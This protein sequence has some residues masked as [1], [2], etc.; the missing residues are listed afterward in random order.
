MRTAES[1]RTLNHPK[2]SL[3][4]IGHT[5][6]ALCPFSLGVRQAR[7]RHNVLCMAGER[8]TM[9]REKEKK[10]MGESASKEQGHMESQGYFGK[11]RGGGWR[12]HKPPEGTLNAG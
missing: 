12:E 5:K 11:C 10:K 6:K 2:K 9:G 8:D 3:G 7:V 4:K 1:G